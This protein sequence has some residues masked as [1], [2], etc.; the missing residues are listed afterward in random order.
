MKDEIRQNDS[1]QQREEREQLQALVE[2]QRN[3]IAS[4]EG[5]NAALES[6]LIRHADE[7]ALLKRKLFGPR[8]E[9]G[10]TQEHQLLLRDVLKDEQLIQKHLDDL[11]RQSAEEGLSDSNGEKPAA[12]EKKRKS[13]PKG[14][15]DLSTSTLDKIVVEIPDSELA[16]KG[17]FIGFEDSYQLG[18][19]NSAFYVI[20]KRLA[21]Y[22]VA[23]ESSA[24][25]LSAVSPKAVVSRGMLHT[26]LLA[27]LAVE[28]FS[29]GVPHYRLEKHLESE[30]VA[31]DRSV[32]SRNMEEVG[33][34][35]GATIVRSMLEHARTCNV[36]ST[37]ATGAAI[38][39]GPLDGG[40]K[41]PCK[42]GHF[43]TIVADRDHVLFEYASEHTSNVVAS[44]FKG[45]CGFLQSDASSVYDI[46]DRGPPELDE[47]GP[48]LVGCWAHCRRYFFEAAICKYPVG[49]EGLTRIRAIYAADEPLA[50]LPPSERKPRRAKLVAPLIDDF[51]AWVDQKART[52]HGRSL[53]TKALG[54]AT[55][56]K[57][58]LRRVLDNGR[59]P[60][61][62]TRSERA[63]RTIVTGRK[64]WLFYGS[65]IHAQA[66]AAIFSVIASCRLHRI[67][68][69]AY[70]DEVLRVL[71]YWPRERYIELSPLRWTTTRA[72]LDSAELDKPLGKIT[73]PE[74]PSAG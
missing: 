33:N 13:P 29:L 40:A 19:R 63:L 34:A 37:D 65:D 22:K 57:A 59:L 6:A 43:F 11:R 49:L 1:E 36:L 42:K 60:L 23:Q 47:P 64:N 27:W 8:S 12:D 52:E 71:P 30:G 50:K 31:L 41:R 74:P 67:D 3:L 28:K 68:P 72:R 70:L 55:N 56:Q 66:A 38:Q 16:A 62:N 51:F 73:V 25:V 24:T 61:D 7:L 5:K 48:T 26:S 14:R 18:R 2:A 10:G 9:R 35:L 44:L 54:Y 69:V 39:P 15:R 53:A 45:F 46:L 4:L 32:M 17:E 20:V 58:E 21:K